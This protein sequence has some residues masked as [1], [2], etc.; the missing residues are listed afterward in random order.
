MWVGLIDPNMEKYAVRGEP[1]L[2]N[3][4]F[5]GDDVGWGGV[6]LNN[7]LATSGSNSGLA[8]RRTHPQAS[9][10]QSPSFGRF[11]AL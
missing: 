9:T 3:T 2:V 1:V 11:R 10:K 8:C 4:H 6:A 5:V 7:M